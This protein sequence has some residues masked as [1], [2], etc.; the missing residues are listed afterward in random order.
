M[1]RT[2]N[3]TDW[4]PAS[5]APAYPGPYEC[6][7]SE[8]SGKRKPK[9]KRVRRIMHWDGEHWLYGDSVPNDRCKPG[10]PALMLDQYGDRW[11]GIAKDPQQ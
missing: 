9:P 2:P 10:M 3:V 8:L 5:M 6:E 11:R 1:K 4:F 7:R